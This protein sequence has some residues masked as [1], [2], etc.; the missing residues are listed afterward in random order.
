MHQFD[1]SCVYFFGI[2]FG[3]TKIR[4]YLVFHIFIFAGHLLRFTAID[5]GFT[6]TSGAV[7]VVIA[8]RVVKIA[9]FLHAIR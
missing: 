2:P 3:V 9:I 1:Q 8:T 4:L 7:S 6:V 5:I